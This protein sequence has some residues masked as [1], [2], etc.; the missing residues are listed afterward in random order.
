MQR[1]AYGTRVGASLAGVW[2]GVSV[3]A[4]HGLMLMGVASAQPANDSCMTGVL[5]AIPP[6]GGTVLGTTV[7]STR[8]GITSC[9]MD[10]NGDFPYSSEGG[11]VWYTF[12]PAPSDPQASSSRYIFDLTRTVEVIDFAIAVH[13][14]C[15][16]SGDD[17][18]SAIACSGDQVRGG[19]SP[20]FGVLPIIV[21]DTRPEFA[22][23]PFSGIPA[24]IVL[25]RG[26]T[27]YVRVG[28]ARASGDDGFFRMDVTEVVA[29]AC[30]SGNTCRVSVNGN[31]GCTPAYFFPGLT[32]SPNPCDQTSRPVNDNCDG[33]VA[34]TV[35]TPYYGN[36]R[37]M[38]RTYV[39]AVGPCGSQLPDVM[40]N[41]TPA[42]DGIYGVFTCGSS[43]GIVPTLHTSCPPSNAN[44]VAC[45]GQ[46]TV[47][48]EWCDVGASSSALYPLSLQGGTTY[49]IRLSRFVGALGSE[50]LDYGILVRKFDVENGEVTIGA[51]CW[52]D[53]TCTLVDQNSTVPCDG[54]YLGDFTTC[55]P[56]VN[57]A[58]YAGACCEPGGGCSLKYETECMNG[59]G[60]YVGTGTTC[61]PTNPCTARLGA[62]C[63]LLFAD[64]GACDMEYREYCGG[65]FLGE[66]TVCSPE[67]C[68][69]QAG[70]CCFQTESGCFPH[71]RERC[72]SEGGT[73][74]GEGTT[75][76]TNPCPE[77]PMGA[78]CFDPDTC[79]IKLRFGPQ[80]CTAGFPFGV[81]LGDGTT[82]QPGLC[83][84]L[85]G[86]CCWT[87][88]FCFIGVESQCSPGE[89]VDGAKFLGAGT[90]CQPNV[91]MSLLGACCGVFPG[92][93]CQLNFE[94][95]GYGCFGGEF[96]GIG[97]T[98]TPTGDCPLDLSGVC[99]RGA[100]C[101][102]VV[103]ASACTGSNTK[104]FA[105]PE[106]NAVGNSSVPCCKAD[107]NHL[108]GITVQD[109]F[110]F[111]AGW[112][113]G[114]AY[115]NFNGDANVS[116]QDIFDFLAAWFA[117]GC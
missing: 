5:P 64:T 8:D 2:R 56:N 81:Y 22:P 59:L 84:P 66:G 3:A 35:G 10:A 89:G 18:D 101:E 44:L 55:G 80:G 112:F 105:I 93:A 27:Y 106:C 17:L 90:T 73:F 33:S 37:R 32:C 49:T 78:C 34:L 117:G 109:I 68:L 38:T 69:A 41:V 86:A 52:V 42:T 61:L 47:G 110:D 113:A 1:R 82:C 103:S 91:C 60:V 4:C 107:Y 88:G 79:V 40:L 114:S 83:A 29:G 24:G 39:D 97:T 50:L 28:G 75:C 46:P 116:V 98:C 111:L 92:I 76:T 87:D 62:C 99:C 25:N 31:L 115:A 14:R 20:V 104:F 16:N 12:T 95:G 74:S 6:T 96:R 13:T 45:Y 100:T 77:P 58:Q 85:A 70:A 67:L 72:V 54:V 11:D 36:A 71:Y 94:P 108:S 15:P 102:L 43:F 9:N 63:K 7:G 51:C 53:R 65:L 30:C 48:D 57:C 23:D 19:S 21:Y 26:Q